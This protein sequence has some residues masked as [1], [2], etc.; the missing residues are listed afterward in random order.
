M[1]LQS[2]SDAQ[3]TDKLDGK[4]PITL[5]QRK[6][7]A[8]LAASIREFSEHGF[9]GARIDRI[10]DRANVMIARPAADL[11]LP[12][13]GRSS[14]DSSFFWCTPCGASICRNCEAVVVEEVPWGDGKRTLTRAQPV[15]TL[16]RGTEG[17]AISGMDRR[18]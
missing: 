18:S 2:A 5:T 4:A 12:S 11:F 3:A 1:P 6:R 17:I 16:R 14:G 15:A 8:I 10:A 13:A 7:A 9:A